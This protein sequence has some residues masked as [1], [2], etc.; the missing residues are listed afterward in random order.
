MKETKPKISTQKHKALALKAA[1]EAMKVLRYFERS[2]PNDDRPR[3]A[4]GI[5]RAWA[6]GKK[7]LG[8]AEVRKLALDAHAAAR[9]A[10]N[11]AATFAARAAGHTIATWHVPTHS[12]GA[13]Y[14]AEKIRA[15]LEK[16]KQKNKKRLQSNPCR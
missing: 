6:K 2:R 13:K 4:I 7:E 1:K 12:L 11:P 3:K 16:E 15:Y 9:A 5:A 10:K 8:M 14:Y